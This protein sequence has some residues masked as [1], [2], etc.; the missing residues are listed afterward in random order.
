MRVPLLAPSCLG[1]IRRLSTLACA[2]A[3]LAAGQ[4]S[5]AQTTCGA[6]GPDAVLGDVSDVSNSSPVGTYDAIALGAQVCNMGSVSIAYSGCPNSH[7]VFGGN[8][9]KYSTVNGAGRFEQI[10]Q[11]WLKHTAVVAA[12]NAC[13]CGCSSSGSGLRPG[14]SDLYSSGFQVS[15]G[16]LGPRYQIN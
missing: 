2:A 3:L 7:P 16:A 6:P 9:Y 4:T 11:S 1:A 5:T 14:C 13:G 8:L 10:G 15:Q 12:S